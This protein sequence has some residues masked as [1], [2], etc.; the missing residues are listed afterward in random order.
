MGKL[1]GFLVAG[2]TDGEGEDRALCR[3]PRSTR[4][5]LPPRRPEIVALRRS[6]GPSFPSTDPHGSRLHRG[7]AFFMSR[8]CP[9]PASSRMKRTGEG[10]VY[11]LVGE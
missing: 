10:V 9:W 7:S 8:A 6:Y 2:L 11:Q 3:A 1:H 5:R 4:P